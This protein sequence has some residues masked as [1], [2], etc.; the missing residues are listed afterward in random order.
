MLEIIEVPG[1]TA[2]DVRIIRHIE[3]FPEL[4]KEFW[5]V[6]EKLQDGDSRDADIPVLLLD[7]PDPH[8][9]A[10]KDGRLFEDLLGELCD[11]ARRLHLILHFRV[12]FDGVVEDLVEVIH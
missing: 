12:L 3:G 4:L 5:M 9:V 1:E 10:V 6:N 2:H 7:G 8:Q 11:V